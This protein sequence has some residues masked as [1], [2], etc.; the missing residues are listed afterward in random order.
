MTSL[1]IRLSLLLAGVLAIAAWLVLPRGIEAGHWLA[2]EDDPARLADLAL[3]R[4][5]DARVAAREIEAALHAGDVEL[6]ESFIA[7]A[8]ERNVAVDPALEA[9]VAAEAS[10]SA[11]AARG[12]GQF[13]RGFVIGE[14]D[15]LVSLAGTAT[16]DLFV[17]GDARDALRE[18][19][20]LARGEEADELILGLACVG[21]AV[22]AG[23]YASL[24]A[25]APARLGLSVIK[26]ARKTGRI[27]TH[28]SGVVVRAVRESVD[29]A[30]LKQAFTRSALVRP[31]LAVRAAREAVKVEKAGGLLHLVRD[32]GRVQSKAGT[33]AALDGLKLAEHPKDVARLARLAEA[34]G[35]KMRAVI[36]LL[37]RGAILLT[38]GVFNL[39]MWVFWAVVNLLM[40]CAAIKRASERIALG[41]IRRGKVRHARRRECAA[42]AAAG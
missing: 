19:V 36:K 16:G 14:P 11:A 18:G 3:D 24:G 31:A 41:V 37:G 35:I 28:L 25:G 8:R 30:A 27:G 32:V 12:V 29:A 10:S 26:A 21:L 22:T 15:D 40:L 4:S 9:T 33:R 23:T 42:V 5:F 2:A 38:T 20:R 34:K 13:V 39:A 6:A 17:F 7:L 1:S